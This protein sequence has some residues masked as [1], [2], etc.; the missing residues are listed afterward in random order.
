[1]PWIVN[2]EIDRVR[3]V[4]ALITVKK[5]PGFSSK[6]RST[7]LTLLFYCES[8]DD[9]ELFSQIISQGLGECFKGNKT[10]IYSIM[11]RLNQIL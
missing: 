4:D 9:I 8:M 2:T 10:T 5:T 11:F 3:L 7:K 6:E 1:M